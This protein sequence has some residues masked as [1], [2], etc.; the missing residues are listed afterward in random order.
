MNF[1]AKLFQRKKAAGT[2]KGRRRTCDDAITYRMRAGFLGEVNRSH[3]AGIEPCLIDASA[4]PT[5]YGQAV[6][7]DA[8]TQGVR[9]L[10]AGDSGLTGVYGFTVRPFPTQAASSAVGFGGTQAEGGAISAASPTPPTSGSTDVLR[11]GY[12]IAKLNTGATAVKGAGVFIWVAA[13][14][15]DHIQG[16]L[17]SAASAGNTIALTDA[18]SV[19]TFNGGADA[20]GLVEIAF[21]V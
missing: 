7:V 4:P 19:A 12:I 10:V 14:S 1:L 17:E 3:P 18:G 6:V 13:T 21:N 20:N 2:F 5:A 15:G 16:G 9:P 8:T 11:S